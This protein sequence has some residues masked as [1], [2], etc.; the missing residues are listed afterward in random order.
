MPRNARAPNDLGDK[1][2]PGPSVEEVE[3]A[4]PE[5]PAFAFNPL[6]ADP[7]LGW[8]GGGESMAAWTRAQAELQLRDGGK[9][10]GEEQDRPRREPRES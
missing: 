5:L 2:E 10:E 7:A 1:A 8:A 9:D 3:D 4:G 6:G